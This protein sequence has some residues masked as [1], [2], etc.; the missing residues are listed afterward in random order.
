MLCEMR[1]PTTRPNGANY[2]RPRANEVMAITPPGFC[3]WRAAERGAC[4]YRLVVTRGGAA[5]YASPLT[6][7]PLH[8]PDVPFPPGPY[9]WHVEAV[10]P[11]GTVGAVSEARAFAVAEGAADDDEAQPGAGR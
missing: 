5:H 1:F 7:D 10:A 9:A 8:V 6:P 3:W 11:D 4:R 2:I